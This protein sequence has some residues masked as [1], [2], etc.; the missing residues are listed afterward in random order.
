MKVFLKCKNKGNLCILFVPYHDTSSLFLYKFHILTRS[1][2]KKS[3]DSGDC[4]TIPH[5]YCQF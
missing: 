3:S 5:E 2:E 1:Y 4:V